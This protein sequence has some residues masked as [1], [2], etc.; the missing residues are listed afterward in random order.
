MLLLAS[1]VCLA[2]TVLHVSWALVARTVHA[3]PLVLILAR[4]TVPTLTIV[5]SSAM[6]SN[7]VIHTNHM[8][9]CILTSC[10]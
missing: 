5:G 3:T 7:P 8:I 1:M 2:L 10:I 4:A 9:L 6:R